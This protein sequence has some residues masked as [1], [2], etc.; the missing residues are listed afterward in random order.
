MRRTADEIRARVVSRVRNGSIVLFHNA[1][2]NTPA[3]LSGILDDLSRKGFEFVSVSQLL[4]DGPT[5]IQHDG[6][7][8]RA[9]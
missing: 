1:A 9:G 4:L 2:L 6:R 3:A 5:K 7:Q 8:T